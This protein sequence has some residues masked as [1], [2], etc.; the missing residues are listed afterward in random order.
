MCENFKSITDGVRPVIVESHDFSAELFKNKKSN[1]PLFHISS[2]GKFEIDIF[3]ILAWV[4]LA[5]VTMSAFSMSIRHKKD[6]KRKMKQMKAELKQV[7][8][9]AKKSSK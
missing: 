3:K 8:R 1:E 9:A 5:L 2:K 7:K 4:A 6:K